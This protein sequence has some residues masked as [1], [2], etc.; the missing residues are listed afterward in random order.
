MTRLALV[1]FLLASPFALAES[2]FRDS[3]VYVGAYGGAHFPVDAWAM[4]SA[5]EGP[6]QLDD[7]GVIGVRVG[8][9]FLRYVG[10]EMNLGLVAVET[11]DGDRVHV[12][13]FATAV[14]GQLDA[15]P[16]AVQG[17]FGLGLYGTGD[18]EVGADADW[19]THL[20]I[21]VKYAINDRFTVRFDARH[22]FADGIED[23]AH[24]FEMAFGVD[25]WVWPWT[26]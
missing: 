1:S 15:G 26:R 9:A 14:W 5:A 25:V 6:T 20:G 2:P 10:L 24:V 8:G 21:G 18:G 13:D 4:G 7:G 12:A 17:R 3:G 16:I 19:N 23:T 22:T 11:R